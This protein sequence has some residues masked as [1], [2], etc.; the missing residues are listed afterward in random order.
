MKTAQYVR[1]EKA[2]AAGAVSD[3]RGRWLYGLR[4]LHDPDV[5][6]PRSTQLKPGRADELVRAAKAV[7]LRLTVREI[8][9]RLQCARAYPYASQIA[10]AGAQFEDWTALRSAG[11]P[12]MPEPA[13]EPVADWRNENERQRERNRLLDDIFG[14]QG[15]LFPDADFEPRETPL[16][17]LEAY[18]V[19]MAELTSRFAE[20]DRKRRAYLNVL[21]E[22]AGG[23][24]L[25]TW[26]D[27]HVRAYGEDVAA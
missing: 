9:Y 10:N 12:P 16:K 20:R 26:Q 1:Q 8:Q 6:A 2:I 14:E 15:T 23:D 13:D 4:L 17:L 19:E 25:M 3:I 18:A 5:F 22:A 21:I 11:F 24:L 27:A 7:G